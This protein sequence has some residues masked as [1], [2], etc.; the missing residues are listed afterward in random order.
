MGV[1][2]QQGFV[3]VKKGE[4][5]IC[6]SAILLFGRNPQKYFPKARVHFIQYDGTQKQFDTQIQVI[7]EAVFEGNILKIVTGVVRYLNV[8]L[9]EII[10]EEECPRYVRQEMIVNAIAHRDYSIQ[11]EILIKL[12][13]DCMIVETPGGLPVPVT[14]DCMQCTHF[15]RN[16]KIVDYLRQYGIM[17]ECGSGVRGMREEMERFGGQAPEY[18]INGTI[19]QAKIRKNA[20]KAG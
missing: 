3:R 15:S 11:E 1:F 19:L 9:K 10:P 7:Q 8:Q 18:K 6:T 20:S 12:F 5:R 14:L 16:P 13:E 17:K 4:R 2:D